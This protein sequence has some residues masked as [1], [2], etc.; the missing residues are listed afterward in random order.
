MLYLD[1]AAAKVKPPSNNI[2]TL[3]HIVD[4]IYWEDSV[5]FSMCPSVVSFKTGKTTIN[6]GTKSDVTNKGIVS[7]AQSKDA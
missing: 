6:K 5:G 3:D 2:I 1:S 4:K 7:V